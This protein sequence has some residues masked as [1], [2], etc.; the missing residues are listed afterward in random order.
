MSKL[1]SEKISLQEELFAKLGGQGDMSDEEITG[2]I[3]EAVL[4]RSRNT[5]L[6]IEDKRQL[7]K[8]L[9]NV[10]RRLDILSDFLEDEDIS[11][12]MI[13][14]Y[15]HIF[16]E[17]QGRLIEVKESFSSEERLRNVIQQ[18]VSGCNRIVNESNPIVDARLLDG[19]RVNVVLPPVALNGATMTIR[20]FPKEFFTMDKL[21]EMGSITREAA[22]FLREL[23]VAGYNIFISGG[24]GSGKTTF[25]NVLSNYIP[26]SDRVITIE[27]AAE[28]QI[29]GIPNLVRMET[30]NANVEGENAVTM[31]SLI[32]AA[33]RMRPTRIIVGEVR[34]AA[35]MDMMNSMLTGHDGSL[36]TGH[37]N[38][39][40]EMMLRLETMILMGYDM[41][42]AAIRQ[43]LSAAIDVVV[44]LGR[45]RDNSRRVLEVCE[46]M[47][48][49]AGNVALSPI[50]E[51]REHGDDHGKVR[52]ALEKVGELKNKD[53]LMRC[54]LL[55]PTGSNDE[56]RERTGD[57]FETERL[58]SI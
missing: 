18:I 43:Q 32:K 3:E 5:Y 2:I 20:K 40:R 6:S 31:S 49:E 9:F 8:E 44:H 58:Q 39:A 41:P 54:G 51:F 22:D 34:D 55:K 42:V 50:Y 57:V 10:F 24:T 27:D 56:K 13:N 48:I 11:E 4:N 1:D 52:G 16:V 17:K 21:V 47:G 30:R 46:V 25:L 38:S 45:L 53:K 19:S 37:G 36:S 23:V 12:I 14:G 26:S 15:R 7:K 28:L 35:A 33:L 29:N